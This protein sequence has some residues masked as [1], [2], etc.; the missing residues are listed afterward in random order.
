[1]DNFLEAS[2]RLLNEAKSQIY[3]WN[4]NI[5]RQNKLEKALG[6]K[7]TMDWKELK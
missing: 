7:F 6:Y 1:M 4:I 3:V 2:R 5:H